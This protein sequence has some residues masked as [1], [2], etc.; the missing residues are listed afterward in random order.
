MYDLFLSVNEMNEN[1]EDETNRPEIRSEA[2][3]RGESSTP[4]RTGF[5][6]NIG[7]ARESD[8]PRDQFRLGDDQ[9]LTFSAAEKRT[10]SAA[11]DSN[12]RR[13][14]SGRESFPTKS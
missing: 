10:R 13:D 1:A 8:G 11:R 2:S 6:E 7:R 14:R 3:R 4:R 5:H 9:S 12:R